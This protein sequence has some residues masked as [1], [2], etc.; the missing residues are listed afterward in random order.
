MLTHSCINLFISLINQLKPFISTN[1]I[2]TTH[3]PFWSNSSQLELF[4]TVPK[5]KQW[6]VRGQ[7]TQHTSVPLC[8]T[9]F[10]GHSRPHAHQN[11]IYC[12][13][14]DPRRPNSPYTV[15]DCLNE[16]PKISTPRFQVLGPIKRPLTA[17][18]NPRIYKTL[19]SRVN[20]V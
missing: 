18:I 7:P 4:L 3:R 11:T 10:H 6:A 14:Y 9:E 20:Q 13:N 8:G 12:I 5:T 15:T 1:F 16:F 19:K 2:H 17:S